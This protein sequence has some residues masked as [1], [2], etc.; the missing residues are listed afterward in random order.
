MDSNKDVFISHSSVDSKLAYAM[1]DFLEEKGIRCWIA[2]RDVQGGTEYAEA[3][4]VGIRN[5][6]IMVVLF[7][8][9]ANDSIYVKN[10]VE[11]A[12]NY[13]SILIPFKVDQT[14]ASATLELFLG[15]V[16]SLDATN[17]NPEDHFDLLYQNCLRVLGKK[18]RVIEENPVLPLTTETKERVI[19]SF[20]SE[21]NTNE[22]LWSYWVSNLTTKTTKYGSI[23]HSGAIVIQPMFDKNFEF[24]DELASVSVNDK[25]GFIDKKGNWV[26]QPMF[27]S[28]HNFS[29]GLAS[30]RVN[31]KCGFIDK[32]GNWVI[33][34]MFVQ[35]MDF[36]DELASVRIN[37]KWGIIDKKGN[38]VIQPMSDQPIDCSD[39]L[40]SV[41]VNDKWGIID[42]KG[43]WVIQPMSDGI[44]NFSDGLAAVE[45][46]EKY[47]YI[48]KKGNWV[49]QPM[50]DGYSSF[51]DG[52]A[53]IEVNEK[54]GFIDKKG[55]WVIQPIFDTVEVFSDGLAAVEV[56][57]KYGYIDKK[58]NWVIQPMF[59]Y[60]KNFSDELAQVKVKKKWGFID[61]KGNLVIQPIFDF[62]DNFI[63]ELAQVR[64]NEKYGFID[65][66]GNWVIQ[67][68]FDK[69]ENFSDELAQVKVKKKWGFIDKK[70]N[71]VFQPMLDYAVNFSDELALVEVNDKYGYID[72]RGNWVLQPTMYVNPEEDLTKIF[73]RAFGD[74]DDEGLDLNMGGFSP[75]DFNLEDYFGN[76]NSKLKIKN[77]I[78]PKKA[79]NFIEN[80]DDYDWANYVTH[81]L[82]VFYDKTFWQN[83]KEGF[84]ISSDADFIYLTVCANGL[85]N[86]YIFDHDDAW[87]ADL[88]Y[89]INMEIV[90]AQLVISISNILKDYWNFSF[91]IN[92]AL[93]E[94]FQ[95]E[96]I[97]RKSSL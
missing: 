60:A 96:I 26:I 89:I 17:G 91:E 58:G 97:P 5:C 20:L 12:F 2:P 4:I 1:C 84:L 47:G 95:E 51:S 86:S 56:N 45:V 85:F 90:N 72:K 44:P 82:W 41:S 39:E 42:K 33:Q 76:V 3:I 35:A 55:N 57:E 43:N 25:Y 49:I 27:D 63:D 48:D 88:N 94:F 46:N 31:D 7:N 10:E 30:V 22:R 74:D 81:E 54:Y 32:K 15:S 34:P 87:D 40:A 80:I 68:M 13:K 52:L 36:S 93:Y 69:A 9:N 23:N 29:D 28:A 6:K 77:Q 11:R 78:D 16:H 92:N 79:Q 64:V 18:E 53:V 19:E 14:T 73:N 75:D 65:K 66:K 67:P 61:K 70:G 8:K 62:A 38:W 21:T 71:W 24:S 83:G 37:D 59:D 50:F